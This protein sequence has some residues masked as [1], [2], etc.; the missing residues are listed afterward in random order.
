MKA[1]FKRITAAVLAAALTLAGAVSAGAEP[2]RYEYPAT[3]EDFIAAPSA[4][5]MYVGVKQELDVILYEKE[6]D[7]RYP[8]GALMRVAMLG[9]A[10]KLIE[11][12]GIDMDTATGEYTLYLFNHYVAGTNIQ[13]SKMKFGEV[14]TV[15]DLLTVC[16]LQAAADSAVTLATVLAGSP[17]QFVEGLNGYAAELGCTNSH[18]TNVIGLNEEGQ[19]MSARDVMTFTR[20]VLDHPVLRKL[21][22][23]TQYTVTPVKGGKT[24]SWPTS[25]DMV[26]AS[27]PFYYL[28]TTGGKTGGTL[29]E[30]SAVEFGGK[31]GYEYMAV[32]MGAP[33]KTE[34]GEPT[35]AVYADARRLIRW[36]L[37]DFTYTLLAQRQEPVA[38]LPLDG[39][40]SKDT[41]ALV[42]VEDLSTVIGKTVDT[43]ALTRQVVGVPQRL[44]APVT[45]GQALGTLELYY[46][47]KLVGT[48]ALVAAEDASYD[49]L[50]AA[51]EAVTAFI[52][53]VWFWVVLALGAALGGGY[54]ALNIYY[55]KRIKSQKKRRSTK[56]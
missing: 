17:E 55:N 49:L 53:S 31:D 46:Q 39:C 33:A 51:W 7:V 16:A 6:A 40:G 48:V 24:R 50:H 38:R 32:V 11:T 14:W 29:T 47:G 36:G 4:M 19:Y 2:L 18:F 22:E 42:P 56:K 35:G 28:Y 54:V 30:K 5:L 10:M 1:W 43:D 34:K 20:V 12:N 26:R 21:L 52:G 27:S 25:N 15:R 8:P 3:E 41:M 45:K 9:Y 13:D 44:Q 37:L 23:L